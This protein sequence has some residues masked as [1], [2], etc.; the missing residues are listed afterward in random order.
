[1]YEEDGSWHVLH[2]MINAEQVPKRCRDWQLVSSMHT[3]M[4]NFA[5]AIGNAPVPETELCHTSPSFLD[6]PCVSLWA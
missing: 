1:M 4:V 3:E 2:E 6:V 5:I